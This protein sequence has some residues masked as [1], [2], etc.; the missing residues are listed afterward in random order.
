MATRNAPSAEFWLPG[1]AAVTLSAGK[2]LAPWNVAANGY[3]SQVNGLKF[4][5]PQAARRFAAATDELVAL[6]SGNPCPN[7]PNCAFVLCSPSSTF[8][9]TLSS[10]WPVRKTKYS[11]ATS[12]NTQPLLPLTATL[13]QRAGPRLLSTTG[14]TFSVIGCANVISGVW[15]EVSVALPGEEIENVCE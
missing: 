11:A 5:L 4:F 12:L 1:T 6:V 3:S 13:S 15:C 7:Q 14:A 2:N 10:L 9:A 8:A